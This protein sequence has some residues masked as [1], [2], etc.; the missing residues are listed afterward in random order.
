MKLVLTGIIQILNVLLSKSYPLLM[1]IN[2]MPRYIR[3]LGSV[4][5]CFQNADNDRHVRVSVYSFMFCRCY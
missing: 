1:F 3:E 4:A 2:K 5:V